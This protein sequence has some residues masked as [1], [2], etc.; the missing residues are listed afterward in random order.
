[1]VE[2]YRLVTG[3]VRNKAAINRLARRVQIIPMNGAADFPWPVV[4]EIVGVPGAGLTAVGT[5]SETAGDDFDRVMPTGHK[6]CKADAACIEVVKRTVCEE[7]AKVAGD[8]V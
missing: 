6:A 3:G 2:Q 1:Q 5:G 7:T 8:A 4:D